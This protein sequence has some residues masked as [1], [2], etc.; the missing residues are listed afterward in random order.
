MSALLLTLLTPDCPVT[1]VTV[2]APWHSHLLLEA[3][4]LYHTAC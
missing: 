2:H 3:G 4:A 1:G